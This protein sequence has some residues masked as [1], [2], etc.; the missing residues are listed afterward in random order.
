MARYTQ[1]TCILSLNKINGYL[2]CVC[3]AMILHFAFLV[4]SHNIIYDPVKLVK[5]AQ[6]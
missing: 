2:A 3:Q 4:G 6:K 1:K 5:K